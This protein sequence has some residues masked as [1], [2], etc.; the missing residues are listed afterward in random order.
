MR[1]LGEQESAKDAA[2]ETFIRVF[3]HIQKVPND[4][5]ALAW[6]F[7]IATNYCLNQ[8]RNR[9]RRNERV[10]DLVDYESIDSLSFESDFTR[11]LSDRDLARHVIVRAGRKRRDIAWLHFVDGLTQ[12]EVAEVLGISRR[13][14]GSQLQRFLADARK[15]IERSRE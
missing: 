1:I 2:Q 5:E 15:F 4:D 13:T 8:L 6:I 11:L 3:R 12:E 7:R 14:V 9:R 10:I